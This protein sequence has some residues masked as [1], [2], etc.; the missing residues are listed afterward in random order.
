CLTSGYYQRHILEVENSEWI[1]QL[2]YSLMQ[3]DEDATFMDKARH[4]IF[5]LRDN[6]IEIIAWNLEVNE[7][8]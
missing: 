5:D 2:K 4:F 7:S 3:R 8:L 6:L 1:N